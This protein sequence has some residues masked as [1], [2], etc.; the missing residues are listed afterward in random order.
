MSRWIWISIWWTAALVL[1]VLIAFSSRW[2][3]AAAL[4]IAA[5]MVGARSLVMLA[6]SW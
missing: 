4:S 3:T 2:Q 1:S 6:K 5:L